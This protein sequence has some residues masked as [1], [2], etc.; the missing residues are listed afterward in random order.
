VSEPFE[1]TEAR[2]IRETRAGKNVL[3]CGNHHGKKKRGPGLP[4][5]S[6]YF[7]WSKKEDNKARTVW[8]RGEK[9]VSTA[10]SKI[11]QSEEKAT[12]LYSILGERRR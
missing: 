9:V 10:I 8:W 3:V 12:R 5:C 1:A 2:R 6:H 11:G 4:C 7:L